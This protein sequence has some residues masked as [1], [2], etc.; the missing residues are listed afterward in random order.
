MK[1]TPAIRFS[2]FTD[3]WKKMMLG[4]MA[5]EI[6]RNNP[7]STA[8]IMM[9]TASNGFIEQSERYS[10][11]NAGESLQKYILLRR[12]ELAYNHGASKLRPYGSC[13]ALT[14]AENARIPFVYHCFSVDGKDSEFVAMEL[15]GRRV[16][17]Q[18]R[19]IVS[20][21]AR[22]D[23]LLNISFKEYSVVELMLPNKQEQQL[24]TAYFRYLDNLIALH[25]HKYE[26]MLSIL[27]SMQEKLFAKLDNPF[28]ENRFS[29]FKGEW[30]IRRLGDMVV[31]YADPVPTPHDG[32][33]RL[34]IRS[35]GKGTFYNHVAPGEELGT[36]QMHRVA[37]NKLIVN[38]TFAWEHAVAV[39]GE[40]DAG[41]LVSHRFPQFSLCNELHPRFLQYLVLD[42]RFRHHLL[43][44]SPGGAGRNRVLKI[45]EM[46]EYLVRVPKYEEQ[47]K[48]ADFLYSLDELT[49][50]Y[51][52]R[53]EKLKNIKAACL[54]GMFV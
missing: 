11:N 23:G 51:A 12:G 10:F 17:N 49:R 31:P 3:D 22:M 41:K 39:T 53:I 13:F 5:K 7:A 37:A 8:P 9:I 16:E 21:T 6:T 27:L 42:E 1:K 14:T 24:L 32:Y 45:D 35:H 26:K 54:E 19:R 50:S 33:E 38:I 25:H 34:G 40:N 4:D 18:L 46:L 15:N 43:L 29:G 36:A 30:E 20:S 2:G 47:E 44:A 28:P 52:M 48:I